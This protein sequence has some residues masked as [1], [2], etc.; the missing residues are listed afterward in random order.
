[1]RSVRYDPAKNT[2][3]RVQAILTLAKAEGYEKHVTAAKVQEVLAAA[4]QAA[5]PLS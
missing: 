4:G 2:A 1:V 3:N 5:G